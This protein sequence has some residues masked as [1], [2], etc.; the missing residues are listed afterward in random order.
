MIEG[1]YVVKAVWTFN[2]DNFICFVTEY[3]IGGDFSKLLDQLGRFD[4]EQARFY[5]AELVL[6]IE[7]LHALGIVHRDLK[8]DNI[9]MDA[10]G[11]IRLT[12]FGLSRSGMNKARGRKGSIFSREISEDTAF[13][14]NKKSSFFDAWIKDADYPAKDDHIEFKKKKGG[15]H[16][17]E[18]LKDDPLDRK[19]SRFKGS[20]HHHHPLSKKKSMVG[21]PDYMAPEV[22]NPDLIGSEG[23]YNEKVIDWW[24]MGVILYQLLIGVPP[25]C[26]D[27][28]EKVFENVQNYRIDWPSIGYDEDCITPEAVDLITKLLNPNPN[29]R[30]GSHGTQEVK[31]HPFFKGFDWKDIREKDGL[32]IPCSAD[33]DSPEGS[34][35]NSDLKEE[36]S[37]AEF[38]L[39]GGNSIKSSSSNRQIEQMNLD[40]FK[41][42]RLDVLDKLNKETYKRLQT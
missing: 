19:P 42:I 22:I 21:T 27:S 24:S 29:K 14:L 7:S 34:V 38:P 36:Y 31:N 39:S 16:L 26:G 20:D 33:M 18:F 11:H 17:F 30:L 8:P 1:D 40:N 12:D 6:A 15:E 35:S 5:F 10:R 2:H 25:F 37:K 3:M 23:E 41:M 4:E 28:V 9:L 32:I 13:S